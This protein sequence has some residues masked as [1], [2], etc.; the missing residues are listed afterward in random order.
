MPRGVFEVVSDTDGVGRAV[1]DTTA[2]LSMRGFAD[3]GTDASLPNAFILFPPR[4]RGDEGHPNYL[5]VE[6]NP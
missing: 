3:G 5:D 6:M 1:V 4:E 2:S